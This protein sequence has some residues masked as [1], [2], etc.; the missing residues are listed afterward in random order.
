MTLHAHLPICMAPPAPAAAICAAA[1]WGCCSAV[2]DSSSLRSIRMRALGENLA[3]RAGRS[4][5]IQSIAADR[6]GRQPRFQRG[7]PTRGGQVTCIGTHT[8][9]SAT[10]H[11]LPP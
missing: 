3:A 2:A 9:A 10:C 11:T 5:R 7:Q 6:P 4:Q 1:V 8:P